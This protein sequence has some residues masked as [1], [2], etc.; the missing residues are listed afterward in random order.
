MNVTKVYFIVDRFFFSFL[1]FV[2]L[3]F[4]V[5]ATCRTVYRS[6]CRFE[7]SQYRTQWQ[8]FLPRKKPNQVENERNVHKQIDEMPQ[9]QKY[10]MENFHSIFTRFFIRLASPVLSLCSRKCNISNVLVLCVCVTL[11]HLF[12]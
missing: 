3:A 10:E 11:K 7:K 5:I 12:V 4:C 8:Y 9:N 6:H 2:P 1:R